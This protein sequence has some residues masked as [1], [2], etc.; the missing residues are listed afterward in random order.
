MGHQQVG[1]VMVDWVYWLISVQISV[2][3]RIYFEITCYKMRSSHDIIYR[4][5]NFN[6]LGE[7]GKVTL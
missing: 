5:C 6:S 2:I 4:H 7:I 3:G 1:V